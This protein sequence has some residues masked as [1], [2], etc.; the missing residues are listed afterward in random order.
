VTADG[1][2]WI[3]ETRVNG[4]SVMRMM[5]ISYLTEERHMQSLQQALSQAAAAVHG[6]AAKKQG[7]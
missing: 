7:S 6:A 2:S 5:V 4:R 1:T 3:S